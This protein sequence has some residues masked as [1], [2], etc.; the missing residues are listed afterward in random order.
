ML[1]PRTA[2]AWMGAIMARVWQKTSRS[3][4]SLAIG[5]T[6]AISIVTVLTGC[7]SS[8]TGEPPCF[9]PK[10]SA[11][12]SNA[13]IGDQ[14]RVSAP[15]A[16]CNPRYGQNALIKI[17]F[18]DSS[19]GTVVDTTAPMNDAGG[20]TYTFSVPTETAAGEGSISAYPYD[21]D[22][23]DDT[24]RNN[25]AHATVPALTLASCAMPQETITI[26]P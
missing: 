17:T 20:F 12:P 18:T 4:T 8:A 16:Q 14:V 22:W 11:D 6:A 15:D 25:R 1:N 9:P 13:R 10:F 2:D 21:I 19:G 3:R 7:N 24:G 26:I 5:L 23:C